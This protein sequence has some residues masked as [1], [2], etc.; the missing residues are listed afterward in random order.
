MASGFGAYWRKCF[1]FSYGVFSTALLFLTPLLFWNYFN[2][3]FVQGKELGFKLLMLLAV[4]VVSLAVLHIR[5]LRI[6]VF[7][8]SG[9]FWILLGLFCL[10]LLSTAFSENTIVALYGS[11]ERG[12][13]LI[14]YLF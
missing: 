13:G 10:M 6:N 5:R 12:L 11:F 7:W 3:S 14:I 1:L 9:I 2:Y 8:R 4:L